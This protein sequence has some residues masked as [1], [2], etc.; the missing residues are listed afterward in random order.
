MGNFKKRTLF[1]TKDC[2][3]I[4]VSIFV[5]DIVT[6]VILIFLSMS[7]SES[8]ILTDYVHIFLKE[9]L[10]LPLSLINNDYPFFLDDHQVPKLILFTMP[11]N[12]LIQSVFFCFIKECITK[13]LVT[14]SN[15]KN[16]ENKK[17]FTTAIKNSPQ[18]FGEISTSSIIEY[19]KNNNS[20][21]EQKKK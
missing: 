14:F 19:Y 7:D 21:N 16:I 10:S 13:I 18:T 6:F 3:Y 12:I 5:I 17:Q 15:K 8:P 2:L 4:G 20:R 9:V 11:A 1:Y